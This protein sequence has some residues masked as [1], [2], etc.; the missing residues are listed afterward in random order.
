MRNLP[1]WWRKI[2]LIKFK[3]I[4]K[5][6][7]KIFLLFSLQ[8]VSFKRFKSI[9]EAVVNS[10]NIAEGKLSKSLKRILKKSV[11]EEGEKL[12]VADT[13]LGTLIKV[14]NFIIFV[15]Y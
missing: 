14:F 10:T 5:N 1:F 11:E 8:L 12:A 15:Y 9:A 7:N 2:R 3:I 6:F 13:Q 4:P